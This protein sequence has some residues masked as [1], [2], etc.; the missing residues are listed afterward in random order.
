MAFN[1]IRQKRLKGC[2]RINI[3]KIYSDNFPTNVDFQFVSILEKTPIFK[4]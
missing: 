1:H 4:H 2:N 3:L